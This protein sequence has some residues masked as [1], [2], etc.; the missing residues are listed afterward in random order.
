VTICER[1]R[2]FPGGSAPKAHG[3]F[4]SDVPGKYPAREYPRL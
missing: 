3:W 2:A 1:A 4:V